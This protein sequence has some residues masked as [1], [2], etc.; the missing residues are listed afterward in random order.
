MAAFDVITEEKDQR[1]FVRE[2]AATANR[3]YAEDGESLKVSSET[4]GH[5]L[6]LLCYKKGAP[7]K[8]Q[9]ESCRS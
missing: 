2:I 1:T 4:V 8:G 9:P 5:A 6:I 3:F 7:Q